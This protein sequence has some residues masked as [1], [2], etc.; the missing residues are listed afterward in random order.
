MGI[1]RFLLM[2]MLPGALFF[3]CHPE[4][5][6]MEDRE[7]RLEFTLDTLFFDTVFTTV[8]TVTKSFRVKNPHKQFIRIDEISLAG[9][10][11]SVFRV[12]VDGDHG[13][14][15][16]GVEIAPNDSMFVFVEATL[17]PNGSDD[18]LR[19]QDSIVFITN[20]TLQDID[21]VAWGQDVHMIGELE[22]DVPTTWVA[23]KPYLV[24]DYVYVDS[25][26]SL[27]IDPGVKVHLHKDA[28][29]I[30]DGS[31]Q[32]SGTRDEPVQF[33]G[34]RLEEFYDQIPGQWGFIYL[35]GSS[36]LNVITHAEIRNG[37]IG[38]LI[39]APPESGVM[40]D[41]EISNSIINR[42]S[43]TGFYALNAVVNGH[44]LVVGD[45]GGSSLA[46]VFGGD[47][48]FTHSTFAN[49]WPSGFSNRQLP[50]VLLTDYFVT[51]DEDGNALL[52]PDGEFENA[53][54][55]NSIIYGAHSMELLI[56]SYYDLQL[57][58]RF[59]YC[60]TRIHE[61]SLRYLDDPLFSNIINNE[62]PLLDSIPVS[63]ELDTLSPAIDAGLPAYAIEF[64]F[65]LN[66]NSRLDDE[67]PDLGA[68]ERIE[69]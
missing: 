10:S 24:I 20:G 21:L 44:N 35:S 50:A 25:A 41:L 9:G 11:A 63:Y 32:I 18:L 8:G 26:A 2:A 60:L 61:D 52:Y 55:R 23:D 58:Y 22:I 69:W 28:M 29:I 62:N 42:M 30:V 4:R 54:F 46:L 40:P 43:S 5:S 15:F 13:I 36:H 47:Y 66:G 14:Q 39:T 51:Y 37:T 65:D 33:G 27:T 67:A 34:D 45:C 7:A 6:Y 16:S 64:P 48:H 56:D 31:L 1:R 49:F 19:I 53:V 57:N 59:D 3:S 38:V 17:D 68:Y 12:N